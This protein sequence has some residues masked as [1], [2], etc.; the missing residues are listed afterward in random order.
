M[1]GPVGL[2]RSS[3]VNLIEKHEGKESLARNRHE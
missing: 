2:L 3:G 1:L